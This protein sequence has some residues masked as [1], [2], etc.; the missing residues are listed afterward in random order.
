MKN[1]LATLTSKRQLQLIVA[2]GAD[3]LD[4]NG[5]TVQLE[6]AVDRLGD[7]HDVYTELG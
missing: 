2:V 6:G 4:P 5:S 3:R 7:A 1:A